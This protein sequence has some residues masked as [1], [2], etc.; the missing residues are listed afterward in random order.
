MGGERN[1]E[2]LGVLHSLT[3]GPV[4]M[5][6]AF[7]PPISFMLNIRAFCKMMRNPAIE[8]FVAEIF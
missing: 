8:G 1:D 2:R 3:S 5:L 6:K 4:S 7:A